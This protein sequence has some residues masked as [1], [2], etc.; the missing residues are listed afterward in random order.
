MK[1]RVSEH[2]NEIEADLNVTGILRRL[3]RKRCPR[4][5]KEDLRNTALR[6]SARKSALVGT[7]V[8]KSGRGGCIVISLPIARLQRF[9]SCS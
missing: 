2:P 7:A 8:G 1:T 3:K 5:C 4:M 6:Y 9:V